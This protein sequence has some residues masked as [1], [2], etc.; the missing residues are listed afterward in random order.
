MSNNI[1]KVE[2]KKSAPSKKKK[3]PSPPRVA[4]LADWFDIDVFEKAELDGNDCPSLTP[5]CFDYGLSG[6]LCLHQMSQGQRW[7]CH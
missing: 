5:P 3:D 2:K 4:A 1:H 6:S 7:D